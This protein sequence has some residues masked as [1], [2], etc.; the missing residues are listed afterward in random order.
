MD[1][2][3]SILSRIISCSLFA[4]RTSTIK[5]RYLFA[6]HFNFGKLCPFFL[7]MKSTLRAKNTKSGEYCLAVVLLAI[8]S[9]T[10][11]RAN[12]RS[13]FCCHASEQT[14]EQTKSETKPIDGTDDE[15]S[16]RVHRTYCRTIYQLFQ[17]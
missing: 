5:T 13:F 4:Q 1:G 16:R 9:N 15:R 14:N 8:C 3:S 11:Q 12:R 17:K 2:R 7:L 10:R 6:L